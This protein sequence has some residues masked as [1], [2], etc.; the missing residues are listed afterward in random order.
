MGMIGP[1]NTSNLGQYGPTTLCTQKHHAF[2]V[3]SGLYG[4]IFLDF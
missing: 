4:R 3:H 2:W 1:Q